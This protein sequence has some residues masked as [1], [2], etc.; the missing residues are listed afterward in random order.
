MVCHNEE[1]F[2]RTYE[3]YYGYFIDE[4]IPEEVPYEAREHIQKCSRCQQKIDELKRLASAPEAGSDDDFLLGTLALHFSCANK[5]ITCQDVKPFL[6]CFA[7]PQS[8]LSIPT[9]VTIHIDKCSECSSIIEQL[10][11]WQLS[12]DQYS[13]LSRF[14]SDKA[15]EN[16]VICFQAQQQIHKI[17]KLDF[18]HINIE[19]IN[20]IC[21]CPTCRQILCQ[22]RQKMIQNPSVDHLDKSFPCHKVLPKDLFDYVLP[23]GLCFSNDDKAAF[24]DSLVMHLRECPKC[25][26]KIQDLHKVIF[27]MKEADS[28]IVTLYELQ[29]NNI[30]SP[31]GDLEAS[32]SN[33]S[34]ENNAISKRHG[35]DIIRR[36]PKSTPLPNRNRPSVRSFKTIIKPLAAAAV[37]L[38]ILAMFNQLIDPAYGFDRIWQALST[39]NNIHIMQFQGKSPNNLYQEEWISKEK[40]IYIKQEKSEITLI[41]INQQT[42]SINKIGSD[43]IESMPISDRD[44]ENLKKMMQANILKLLPFEQIADIPENAK[45]NRLDIVEADPDIEVYEMTWVDNSR[46]SIDTI[47]KWRCYVDAETKLTRKSEWL[48]KFADQENYVMMITKIAKYLTDEEF[49][50]ATKKLLR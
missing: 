1:L 32:V 35:I 25:L 18:V 6:P 34:I 11:E 26:G 33:R 41:D 13:R 45:W 42:I 27:N 17:A 49:D 3:I 19:L 30:D 22:E 44:A 40:N 2:C 14:F 9:P 50:L 46:N 8:E 10:S 39:V 4:D 28:G 12:N 21:L 31:A 23:Y 5:P 16:A 7:I 24:R 15:D 38:I 47:Q 43:Q 48:V 29:E 20:H 37:F 36:H